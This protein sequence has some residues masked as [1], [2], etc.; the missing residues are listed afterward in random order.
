MK[1]TDSNNQVHTDTVTFEVNLIDFTFSGA[2][3]NNSMA[4]DANNSLNF[5]IS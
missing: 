1:I 3:Q 2:A 4:I 5:N